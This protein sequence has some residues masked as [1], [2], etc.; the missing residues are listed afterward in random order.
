MVDKQNL[1][2][3]KDFSDNF[4]VSSLCTPSIYETMIKE[5]TKIP[6]NSYIIINMKSNSFLIKTIDYKEN[7]IPFETE[8][9]LKIIDK[10]ID[11]WGYII[12]SL[13]N[14]INNI[15]SNLSG[16]FDT[17]VILSILLNSGI[18]L[19]NILINSATDKKRCHDEDFK[20]ATNISLKYGFKLNN[21]TLDRNYTKWSL[22]DTLFCTIYTKLGFHK[23]FYWKNEFL[24]SQDLYLLDA[25]K[26]EDILV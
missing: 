12:R 21:Y 11:K 25:G 1:S 7:T 10:W 14:K 20:I 16:G 3:N 19:N 24:L 8:E 22:K 17:R 4:A 5:I 18:N 26:L 15:A 23:E 9:G 2:L 6:S 13:N